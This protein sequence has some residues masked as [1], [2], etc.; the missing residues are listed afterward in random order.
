MAAFGFQSLHA[1]DIRDMGT[2]S[3][4]GKPYTKGAILLKALGEEKSGENQGNQALPAS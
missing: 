2:L 4:K 1:A 3:P